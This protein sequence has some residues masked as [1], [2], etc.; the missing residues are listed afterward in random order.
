MEFKLQT[1]ETKNNMGRPYKVRP[2]DKIFLERISRHLNGSKDLVGQPRK[3][4]RNFLLHES[5]S[6][7]MRKKLWM[8]RIG[9]K[10]KISRVIYQSLKLRASR[11]DIPK[12]VERVIIA[13]LN[14]TLPDY[15]EASFEG[16]YFSSLHM[17]L[18]MFQMYRPDIGY[19]QGMGYII[20]ILL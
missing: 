16:I 11:E 2:N 19:V 10:V 14:R 8:T 17:H 7:S 20:I 18:K 12:K 4:V 15:F 9:N 1:A 13:D 6:D 3:Q 5:I